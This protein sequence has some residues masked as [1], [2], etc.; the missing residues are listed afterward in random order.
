[1]RVVCWLSTLTSQQKMQKYQSGVQ[2]LS[3]ESKM[4]AVTAASKYAQNVVKQGPST[5]VGRRH[6]TST[7]S[8]ALSA[9]PRAVRRPLLRRTAGTRATTALGSR[10]SRGL[11]APLD[12]GGVSRA[13]RSCG[14]EPEKVHLLLEQ[15]L[16][17]DRASCHSRSAS[18]QRVSD[19][20]EAR[21][22]CWRL[23]ARGDGRPQGGCCAEV[24]RVEVA[25]AA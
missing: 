7:S 24:R 23:A 15:R 5:T 20:G 25:F 18:R 22:C 17:N 9:A 14:G 10:W 6:A 11:K 19:V 2:I 4:V 1:M 8:A 13:S 21:C 3:S 12:E 16:L